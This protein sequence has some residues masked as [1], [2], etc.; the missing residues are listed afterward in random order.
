MSHLPGSNWGP[1]LYERRAL[2]TELRWHLPAR[3]IDQD[4]TGDLVITNDVLYQLSYN[5]LLTKLFNLL[6][7]DIYQNSIQWLK[8]I[9]Y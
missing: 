3:A 7:D 5:G 9:E 6:R 8:Q 1:R 4:R 2:P